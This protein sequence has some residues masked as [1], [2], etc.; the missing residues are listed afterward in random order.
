MVQKDYIHKFKINSMN[1]IINLQGKYIKF[2]MNNLIKMPPNRKITI[3]APKSN[4]IAP[5]LISSR[6]MM[7][8]TMT[9]LFLI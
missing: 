5:T 6:K 7:A 3:K 9:Y 4:I 1:L 8:K 2:A